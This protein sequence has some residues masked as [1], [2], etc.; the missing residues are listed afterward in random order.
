[1]RVSTLQFYNSSNAQLQGRQTDL[2]RVQGQLGSGKRLLSAA[3]DPV[4]TQRII[5]IDEALEQVTQF[6]RNADAVTSRL[7]VQDSLVGNASNTLQRVREL[8]LQGK[9]GTI[10]NQDRRFLAAEL[11]ARLEEVVQ[12]ANSQDSNGDFLFAGFSTAEKPFLMSASGQVTFVGDQGSREIP[13]SAERRVADADSGF[14]VFQDIRGGNGRFTFLP[15][16]VNAGTGVLDAGEL[17]DAAAWAGRSLDIVFTGPDTFDV[18]DV[19]AGTT[20]ASGL[21]FNSGDAINVAGVRLTIT[22]A[23]A[24]GDTFEVRPSQS[25]PV[26]DT[27]LRTA[28]AMEQ[29]FGN[30]TEQAAFTNAMNR[31]LLDL[32]QALE[33]ILE[34][35]T[36]VGARLNA[37]ETQRSINEDVKLQLQTSRSGLV[38]LDYT[39]A[40]IRLNQNLLALQAAQQA[41]V[42]TS[43]LNLFALL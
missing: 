2:L 11:R 17:T 19:V 26:F 35:Q 25:T 38:D 27:I 33:N 15:S 32:D 37:I 31:S 22:G 6:N 29:G 36:S 28:Q 13:I 16:T 7:S 20:V 42:R 14:R 41:F 21:S 1:M 40:S 23:P 3:D 8:I 18:F 34:V 10:S 12:I 43:G 5:G 4:A 24:A 9:S 30:P 39:D